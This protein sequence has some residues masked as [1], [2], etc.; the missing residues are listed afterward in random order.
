MLI[1]KK[2]KKVT[3]NLIT[4]VTDIGKKKCTPNANDWKPQL[5]ILIIKVFAR[6]SL[7]E[8]PFLYEHQQR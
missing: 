1:K 5:N 6:K 2:K 7:D 8:N 4:T 3:E